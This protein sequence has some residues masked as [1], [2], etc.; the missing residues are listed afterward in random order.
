MGK[1]I[2]SLDDLSAELPVI[3]EADLGL[4]SGGRPMERCYHTAG[5]DSQP[6]DG[7]VSDY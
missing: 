4:V 6:S 5:T 3:D 2:V 7:W 1:K